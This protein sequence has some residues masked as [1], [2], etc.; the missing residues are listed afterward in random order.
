[1]PC[2]LLFFFFLSARFKCISSCCRYLQIAPAFLLSLCPYTKGGN[3]GMGIRKAPKRR[4]SMTLALCFPLALCCPCRP[5]CRY[6]PPAFPGF[7]RNATHTL[8]YTK[9]PLVLRAALH[10]RASGVEKEEKYK[11]QTW[12]A[13]TKS[14]RRRPLFS[15]H[16]GAKTKNASISSSNSSGSRRGDDP[17]SLSCSRSSSSPRKTTP[18]HLN[19][20]PIANRERGGVED[21]ATGAGEGAGLWLPSSPPSCR[22]LSPS[23]PP[24]PAP[25]LLLLLLRWAPSSPPPRMCT[26]M[27][28][29][30]SRCCRIPMTVVVVVV[31]TL[32]PCC[33]WPCCPCC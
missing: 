5:C 24:P 15:Q 8:T 29:C 32:S 19:R 12:L 9:A 27:C 23:P 20:R 22:P 17:F 16:E 31:A 2:F 4:E 7:K 1:M 21:R 25:P 13:C 33:P 18:P 11:I 3:R 30:V 26:C 28:A 6:C 14:L 10:G